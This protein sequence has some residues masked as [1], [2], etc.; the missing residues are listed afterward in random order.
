MGSTGSKRDRLL[1]IVCPAT[2]QTSLAIEYREVTCNGND[3]CTCYWWR[4]TCCGSWHFSQV[5]PCGNGNVDQTQ[6]MLSVE[7]SVDQKMAVLAESC[8]SCLSESVLEKIA[9]RSET[10]SYSSD[11]VI[12]RKGDPG[13]SMYIIAQGRVEILDDGELLNHLGRGS[14]F[15]EMAVLDDMPRL[16]T[17]VATED[18]VLISLDK[19]MLSDLIENPEVSLTLVRILTG[20]LRS[21]VLDLNIARKANAESE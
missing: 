3:G 8:F 17:A 16:A 15:G 12:F 21:R 14:V 5:S 11:E 20:W 6:T 7:L 1:R 19:P 9:V 10:A 13:Y 4:C 2:R 18:T